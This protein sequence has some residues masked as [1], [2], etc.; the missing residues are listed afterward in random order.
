[1]KMEHGGVGPI[2]WVCKLVVWGS[3][4]AVQITMRGKQY[5]RE[6]KELSVHGKSRNIKRNKKGSK[7]RVN[8]L[9]KIGDTEEN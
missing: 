2:R 8:K 3:R 1:M 7:K 9:I 6:R 5:V 4:G